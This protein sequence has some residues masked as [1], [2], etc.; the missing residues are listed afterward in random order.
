M[1]EVD[2]YIKP[3]EKVQMIQKREVLL[4][5]VAEVFVGGQ[6]KGEAEKIVVFQIPSDRKKTYLLSVIDLIRALNQKYPDATVSNVGEMDILIEYL[7][8]AKEKAKL[9][10]LAKVTFV[11]L[12]LFIGAATTIMCFHS[13]VQLPLVFQ[14]IYYIFFGENREMSALISVPYSIGLGVGIIIFF[15][16]FSKVSLTEDPTPIEIE[17]TTYEKE[18]NASV[19][20]FLGRRK[21]GGEK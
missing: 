7:P 19:I 20:D 4:R 8:K 21:G 18:T 14:N 5:D 9:W 3:I 11:S 12:T 10:T 16:H 17:M 13:D 2:I 1:E 6:T 15:N